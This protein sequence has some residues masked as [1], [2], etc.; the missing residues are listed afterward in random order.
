[1][2]APESVGIVGAGPF[3]LALAK[4]IG[5]AGRQVTLWSQSA[6]VVEQVNREHACPERL[7]GAALPERVH[8]TRDP[9]ELAGAARFLVVAVASTEVRDRCRQLGEV[10]DGGHIVVHA[11]GAFASPGDEPVSEVLRAELPV[12]RCGALAGP[13]LAGDLAERRYSSMVCASKFDEVAA[14]ARRLLGVAPALR[15]YQGRD[16]TGVELAAALAG[17]YTVALGIADAMGI[18][19]GE[20]AT[21]ITRAVAESSRLGEALGADARTF[22]GLAG[23]GNLLVR[24]SPGARELSA[25]YAFGTALGGGTP[26]QQLTPTEGVRAAAAAV[27]LAARHSVRLRLLPAMASVM[28]GECTPRAAALAAAESVALAE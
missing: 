27:R 19:A 28:R 6:A 14:E 7:P 24:T 13:A 22:A 15:I 3:G 10:L 25:D 26:A 23:L 8:A 11:I 9:A 20:R 1:M 5:E 16:L 21:L 4:L 12:L 18:G 17:A 2:S